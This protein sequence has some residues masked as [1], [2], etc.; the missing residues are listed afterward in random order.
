MF[1]L[2]AG[3]AAV[4][5]FPPTDLEISVLGV[6]ISIHILHGSNYGGTVIGGGSTGNERVRS[7]PSLT[8]LHAINASSY[9]LKRSTRASRK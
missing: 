2:L 9:A 4:V 5:K 6:K 8:K 7:P 1:V 3:R